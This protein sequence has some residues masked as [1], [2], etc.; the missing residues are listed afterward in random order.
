MSKTYTQREMRR[1]IWT[2]AKPDTLNR[3]IHSG[4]KLP[5]VNRIE[6]TLVNVSSEIIS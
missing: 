4:E 6:E 2:F 1:N 3:F 5:E